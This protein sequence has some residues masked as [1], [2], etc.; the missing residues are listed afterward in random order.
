[1]ANT[2]A[3]NLQRLVDV[4]DAIGQAII[5][6]GGTVQ[7]GDRL[8]EYPAD[9]TT[10]PSHLGTKN[11]T[12]DGVYDATDDDLDGFSSV[13]VEVTPP[14]NAILESVNDSLEASIGPTT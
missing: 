1:M 4:T 14:I 13:T 9:I 10:I 5:D 12:A 6:A 3:D 7:E 8:E 2:I 11:I